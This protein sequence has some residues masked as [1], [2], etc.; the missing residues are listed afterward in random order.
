MLHAYTGTVQGVNKGT[1]QQATMNPITLTGTGTELR[2][3][4]ISLIERSVGIQDIYLK[5]TNRGRFSNLDRKLR[6]LE[7]FD[8]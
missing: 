2:L 3:V 5:C 8:A 7:R 6:H 4:W 1:L